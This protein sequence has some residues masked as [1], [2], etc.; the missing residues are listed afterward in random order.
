MFLIVP[1][2]TSKTFGFPSADAMVSFRY[3]KGDSITFQNWKVFK[4]RIQNSGSG[5][6]RGKA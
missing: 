6:S 5:G 3:L 2:M 1:S 4:L